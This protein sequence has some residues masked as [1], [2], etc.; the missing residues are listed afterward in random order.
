MTISCTIKTYAQETQSVKKQLS[1]YLTEIFD[2][3]KKDKKKKTGTYIVT[4]NDNKTL[5]IGQYKDNKKD[6]I[7][8]YLSANGDVIQ[9]YD[10]T[11]SKKLS[12]S[13]DVATAVGDSFQIIG[14]I[15]KSDIITPP[16][17]IGGVN[18]GFYL[19]YSDRQLP[20]EIK[21]EKLNV[22]LNLTY[23]FTISAIG[24]LESWEI[25]TTGDSSIA[26][27]K[28][29]QSLSGLPEDAYTFIAAQI[30]GKGVR[31][32][33]IYTIPLDLNVT[34]TRTPAASQNNYMPDHRKD[35]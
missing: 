29:E 16:Y 15:K 6:S 27:K 25:E 13:K 17:K 10:Y 22:Q 7:W 8:T 24:K 9:Q 1:L 5:V 19:L 31:S 32:Q 11:N 26:T 35:N 33:L 28:E 20:K 3:S 23:I 30:N 18:Y 4:N 34:Q 21:T 2:V 14:S 12:E